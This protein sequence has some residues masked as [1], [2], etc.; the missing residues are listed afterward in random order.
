MFVQDRGHKADPDLSIELILRGSI[1]EFKE[2]M[3]RNPQLVNTRDRNHGNVPLHVASSKGDVQ[4]I[5]FLLRTG[6][7]LTIQDVFGNS[8]LHYATDK[9]RISAMDLLLQ[10][11]ANP[12]QQDFKGNSPIHV[13]CSNNDTEAVKV[14]LKWNADPEITDFADILP[15]DKTRSPMIKGLIDRR[16]QSIHGGDADKAGQSMNW[17]SFGVGLGSYN[18]CFNLICF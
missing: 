15:R 3:L 17:M 13:A 14:L 11:G 7:H 10:A 2:Y 4:L 6:A 8:S 9:G 12:N 16:L 1:E 5:S 18:V